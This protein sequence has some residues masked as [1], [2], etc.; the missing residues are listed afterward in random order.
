MNI[1]NRIKTVLTIFFVSMVV[2]GLTA[3]TANAGLLVYEPF[4]YATGPID[5]L[6]VNAA[7]LT[8]TWNANYTDTTCRITGG[9]LAYSTLPVAGNKFTGSL[10]SDPSIEASLDPAVMAGNMDDGDELWF[11]AIIRNGNKSPNTYRF[12]I[13]NM[14]NGMGFMNFKPSSF[15]QDII[16]PLEFQAVTW[17][18]GTETLSTGKISV[19]VPEGTININQLVVGKIIFGATDTIRIYVPDTDLVLPEHDP[20]TLSADLD[21]S[22]LETIKLQITNGNTLNFDEIRIGT[23]YKYVSGLPYDPN[24]PDIHLGRDKVTV[25]GLAGELAPTV[26]NND[27]QVPQ[28]DLTYAWTA[29]PDTGVVITED[30]INPDDPTTPGATV[31]ITDDNPSDPSIVKL[32]L[33]AQLV[34][35]PE[36]AETESMKIYVYGDACQAM[37]AAGQPSPYDPGDID[38]NCITDLRDYAALAAKWLVDYKATAP[39]PKP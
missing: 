26:I 23:K 38:E 5:G 28:R 18:D 12:A 35:A 29:V 14:T 15:G 20:I 31:T 7:G 37:I 27:T 33:T 32:T 13:G 8:G 25:S 30:G 4:N 24:S 3:A 19:P 9:S 2:L 10:N 1:K 16:Y 36:T 21:Q 34:G 39:V 6:T 17:V 11:S 22:T